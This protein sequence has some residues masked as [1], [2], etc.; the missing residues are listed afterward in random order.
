MKS[1]W[2]NWYMNSLMC[3]VWTCNTTLMVLC[4]IRQHKITKNNLTTHKTPQKTTKHALPNKKKKKSLSA[5]I[6]K[7]K[8]LYCLIQQSIFTTKDW[9][10]QHTSSYFDTNCDLIQFKF[11]KVSS[12][13]F[14]HFR[15][16]NLELKL[17]TG[18]FCMHCYLFM[19]LYSVTVFCS[20]H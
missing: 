6:K 4:W 17:L 9:F 13:D 12:I 14:L 11:V 18:T 5:F 10:I 8:C 1:D 2:N 20:I 16:N 3:G 15:R 7:K 19:L